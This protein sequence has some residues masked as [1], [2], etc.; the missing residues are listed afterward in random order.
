MKIDLNYRL[1]RRIMQGLSIYF[2]ESIPK[3]LKT[4]RALKKEV[5]RQ[6]IEAMKKEMQKQLEEEEDRILWGDSTRKEQP[7]G[8][9]DAFKN[10]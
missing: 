10:Q 2:D 6:F 3:W 7:I 8:I 5:K 1:L 4:K 9:I